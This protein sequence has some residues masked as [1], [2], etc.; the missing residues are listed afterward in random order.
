[1]LLGAVGGT[2]TGAGSKGHSMRSF[3]RSALV[4]CLV[5]CVVGCKR[6]PKPV[7]YRFDDVV[8]GM[9]AVNATTLVGREGQPHAYDQL[10]ASTLPPRAAYKGIPAETTWLVWKDEKTGLSVLTLGVMEG[11]VIYKD[12]EWD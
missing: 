6:T 8:L 9:S 12:V 3:L 11:R 2:V 1:M 4:A 10:P 5:T 7:T